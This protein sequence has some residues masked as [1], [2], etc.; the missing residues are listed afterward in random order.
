M[1]QEHGFLIEGKEGGIN[2]RTFKCHWQ[3]MDVQVNQ[4][5]K[6]ELSH[7]EYC[8]GTVNPELKRYHWPSEVAL[9]TIGLS[10]DHEVPS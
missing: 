9:L 6:G 5:I 7:T 1:V 4:V 3:L 8:K 2:G 10:F